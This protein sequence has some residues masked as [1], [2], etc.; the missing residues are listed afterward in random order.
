MKLW[1][2]VSVMVISMIGEIYYY[3]L[4]KKNKCFVVKNYEKLCVFYR[5]ELNYEKLFQMRSNSLKG[6]IRD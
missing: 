5:C 6:L 3:F 1:T 4:N 2:N